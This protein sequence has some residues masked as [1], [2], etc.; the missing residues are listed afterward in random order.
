MTLKSDKERRQDQLLSDLTTL[1]DTLGWMWTPEE[2][3]E[4]LFSPH[5]LLG[6]SS[7]MQLI[8]R[9]KLDTVLACL[10]SASNG[11]FL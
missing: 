6:G 8:A 3:L 7:A 5:E 10:E 1:K 11:D 4:W 9:G 2:A